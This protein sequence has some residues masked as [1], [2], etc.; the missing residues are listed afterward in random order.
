MNQNKVSLSQFSNP[1]TA[2]IYKAK[3][4]VWDAQCGGCSYYAKLNADYGLCCHQKSHHHLETVLEHFSCKSIVRESWSYHS[5]QE[6]PGPDVDEVMGYLSV[7]V[8]VL[9]K[10]KSTLHADEKKLILKIKHL[11]A[12]ES[13]QGQTQPL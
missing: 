4:P 13:T 5:F 7:M 1:E 12:K 8:N 9:D 2:A 6:Q 3:G 11:L 10:H